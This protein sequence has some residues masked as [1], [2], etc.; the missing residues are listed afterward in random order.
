MRS[1]I[2]AALVA[3]VA[4]VPITATAASGSHAVKAA[5]RQSRDSGVAIAGGSVFVW[6]RHS[7]QNRGSGCTLAF[8]VR[9]IR[10]GAKGA[11]TAG[12]CVATLN[13]GPAYYV[14]QTQSLPHDATAPGDL[15][16]KVSGRH[17]VVGP[18]GDSAFASLVP[19]RNARPLLFTGGSASRTAIP[20]AGVRHPHTGMQICYS[21]AATGEH[22]GFTIVGGSQD[23]SFKSG[24]GRVTIGN[25]W[26]ATGAACTSRKGDSGSPVYVVEGGVAYAVGILSG[27]QVR[28]G[29]CPFYFT[30]VKLALKSL[31]VKLITSK[32][33]ATS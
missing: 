28:R 8:S 33:G 27:G 13:G 30:P 2:L 7:G 9:S 20:V 17:Y 26:R 21:G 5:S 14:Q 3:V 29:R 6:S 4:I 32:A 23:V 1:R 25:E 31:G 18:N 19:G 24:N 16:G 15:L 11:L 10:S 12:H 22:C